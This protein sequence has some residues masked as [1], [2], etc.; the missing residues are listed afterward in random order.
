M[1]NL[2]AGTVV[3]K[4]VTS[5][6]HGNFYLQAHSGL[7]GTALPTHYSVNHD[8]SKSRADQIQQSN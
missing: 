6:L 7:V 3:D 1:Q 8:E 5:V 2:P 4:G